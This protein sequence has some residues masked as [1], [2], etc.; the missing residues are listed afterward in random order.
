MAAPRPTGWPWTCS[1]KPSTTSWRKASCCAPM[2]PTSTPQGHRAPVARDAARRDHRQEPTRGRGA[3]P[4]A[5]HARGFANPTARS[6][7]T[8]GVSSND[9]HKWGAAAQARGRHFSAPTPARAWGDHCAG[10]NHV[11][12]TGARRF[13]SPRLGVYDFQKRSSIIEVSQQ[14][15]QTLARLPACWRGTARAC[16]ATCACGGDVPA[17]RALTLPLPSPPL[18]HRSCTMLNLP[19]TFCTAGQ[20]D[21]APPL[22]AGADARWGK[23]ARP[24]SAWRRKFLNSFTSSACVRRFAWGRARLPGLILYRVPRRAQPHQPSPKRPKAAPC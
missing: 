13:C 17:A 4:H 10:P 9:P 22:A 23:R 16:R 14:G 19:F 8:L 20:P 3:D 6:L 5:Q 7:S 15:A 11:P 21:G 2:P 24:V 1:A 12:P 18:Q